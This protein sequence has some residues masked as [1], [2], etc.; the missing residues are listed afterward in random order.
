MILACLSNW[1]PVSK[2]LLSKIVLAFFF[3][4]FPLLYNY[5]VVWP[6]LWTSTG[7]HDCDSYCI[8]FW[9]VLCVCSFLSALLIAV[10]KVILQPRHTTARIAH[11]YMIAGGFGFLAYSFFTV[12][13]SGQWQKTMFVH[14]SAGGQDTY[15]G[16]VDAFFVLGS[17]FFICDSVLSLL[18]IAD[19]VKFVDSDK[20]DQT[21]DDDDTSSLFNVTIGL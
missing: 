17:L 14:C 15:S 4:Y 20:N 18:I 1:Q 7:P 9:V 6:L 8:L 19:W 2:S 3:T 11:F 10:V 21:D 5:Y 16:F 13:Q 12:S